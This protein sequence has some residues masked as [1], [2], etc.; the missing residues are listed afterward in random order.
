MKRKP[1]RTFLVHGE[2]E[3]AFALADDLREQFG[4]TVDVPE[5]KQQ[6]EL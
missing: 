2:E 3:S 5:W 6:F 1:Q 4:L